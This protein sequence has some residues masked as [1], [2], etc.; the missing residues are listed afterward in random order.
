[1]KSSKVQAP[2]DFDGWW[3]DVA[4]AIRAVIPARETAPDS[5]GRISRSGT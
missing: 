4:E 5:A 1:L 2:F 3:K